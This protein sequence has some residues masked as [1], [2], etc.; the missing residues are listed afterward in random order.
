M[1]EL[2]YNFDVFVSHSSNDNDKTLLIADFLRDNGLRVWLDLW[3]IPPSAHRVT[4]I[5]EGLRQSRKTLVCCSKR[6]TDSDWVAFE[7]S[8]NILDDPLNRGRRFVLLRLDDVGLPVPFNQFQTIDW[9]KKKRAD[10]HRRM[11]LDALSPP[12][13]STAVG[14][15][16]GRP[17]KSDRGGNGKGDWTSHVEET[18]PD[19]KRVLCADDHTLQLRFLKSRRKPVLLTGHARRIDCL[20]W[21]VDSRRALSGSREGKICLWDIER[22]KRERVLEGHQGEILCLA[23]SQDGRYALSG[24]RDNTLRHW[25]LASGSCRIHTGHGDSVTSVA[26]NTNPRFALTGSLDK[27][28][29]LWD[30]ELGICVAMREGHLDGIRLV[31]WCP[32]QRRAVSSDGVGEAMAWDFSSSIPPVIQE[33]LDYSGASSPAGR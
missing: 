14:S 15:S 30:L 31:T 12:N 16:V 7:T 2:E 1:G 17:P 21:S 18:S 24:A 33:Q 23:F 32:D 26:W 28:V 11:L 8:L 3:S 29:R 27:L 19:G 22:G 20:A 6:A 25:E 5:L 9:F 10:E 4:A 13:G